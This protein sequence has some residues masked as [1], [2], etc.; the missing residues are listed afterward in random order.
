MRS[1]WSQLTC[2]V[3][4]LKCGCCSSSLHFCLVYPPGLARCDHV[5]MLTLCPVAVPATGVAGVESWHVKTHLHM[6]TC[7]DVSTAADPSDVG[8]FV[9]TRGKQLTTV[10]YISVNQAYWYMGGC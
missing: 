7:A 3:D 8:S 6:Q 5:G 1:I 9:T 10:N 4:L 2:S